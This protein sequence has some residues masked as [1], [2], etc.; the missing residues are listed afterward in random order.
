[1]K[2]IFQIACISLSMLTCGVTFADP[3]PIVCSSLQSTFYVTLKNGLT[4]KV[5]VAWH[6][7]DDRCW[8][9]SNKGVNG[10]NFEVI[11]FL[12]K[13]RYLDKDPEVNKT[14]YTVYYARIWGESYGYKR[15]FDKAKAVEDV[16]R[17]VDGALN[18]VH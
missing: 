8:T 7:E 16:N 6:T 9:I 18:G 5:D 11:V 2:R 13:N 10:N 12:D 17:V 4:K 15:Y 3:S 14:P 1:M